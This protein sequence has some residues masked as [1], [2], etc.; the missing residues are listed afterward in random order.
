[1]SAKHTPGPWV[2]ETGRANI[3]G[4]GHTVWMMGTED[5]STQG[6]GTAV[7][8]LPD[9]DDTPEARVEREATARFI[10]RAVNGHAELLEALEECGEALDNVRCHLGICGPGDGGDRKADA[11]DN[12]GILSALDDARA[13]IAKAKGE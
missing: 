12:W 5:N 3:G 4:H 6:I 1:M 2:I 10:C 9:E 7:V 13:T 8:I 11:P